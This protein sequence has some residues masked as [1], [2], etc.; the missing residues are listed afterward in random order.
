[1][2]SISIHENIGSALLRLRERQEGPSFF[3][4]QLRQEKKKGE[5]EEGKKEKERKKEK[6]E[7]RREREKERKKGERER[8]RKIGG[9]GFLLRSAT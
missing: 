3:Y 5:K 8:E 6:K 1:M 2:I 4:S 7:K 9:G